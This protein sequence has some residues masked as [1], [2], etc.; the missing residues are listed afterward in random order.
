MDAKDELKLKGIFHAKV[1]RNGKLIEEIT[2]ENLIVTQ[3]KSSLAHLLGSDVTGL[4]VT[5][6]GVGTGT[7][8]PAV[9]DTTITNV[10][11]KNLDSHNYPAANQVAFVWSLGTSEANGSP[12]TEFALIS[13]NGNLFARRTRAAINKASDISIDGTWTIIF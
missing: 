13:T 6:I 4:S 1:Y 3:G 12:L 10:L 11:T 7:T 8:P 9:G 5:K 2:E